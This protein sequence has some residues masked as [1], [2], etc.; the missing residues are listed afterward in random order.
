M[1]CIRL[2]AS[3][4]AIKDGRSHDDEICAIWLRTQLFL[5][6][7]AHKKARPPNH[8]PNYQVV[9]G[10]LLRSSSKRAFATSG[11]ALVIN[12]DSL[13]VRISV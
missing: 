5:L 13:D 11:L 1:L 3:M 2:R 6:S 4:L 9:S 8:S 10:T 7:I 12:P